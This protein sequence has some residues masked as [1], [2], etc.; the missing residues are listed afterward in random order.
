MQNVGVRKNILQAR[1]PR[2]KNPWGI[3]GLKKKFMPIPNHPTP[4]PLQKINGCPL[5]YVL[6]REEGS[7]YLDRY[8][9]S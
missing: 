5:M 2:K 8:Y 4:P 7:P 1:T 3:K 9:Y 6:S